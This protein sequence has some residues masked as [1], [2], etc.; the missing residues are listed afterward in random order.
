M[1][2]SPITVRTLEHGFFGP[3]R[4]S[5]GDL[6]G[7]HLAIVLRLTPYRLA[8][9]VFF[10]SLAWIAR[11][12]L[13]VVVADPCVRPGGARPRSRPTRVSP[14]PASEP[15]AC[16]KRPTIRPG[17]ATVRRDHLQCKLTTP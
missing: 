11:R 1:I 7:F 14:K 17:G 6:R 3:M 4:S 9:T 15:G 12:I 10:S 16:A 2:A 13:G 5:D 8:K